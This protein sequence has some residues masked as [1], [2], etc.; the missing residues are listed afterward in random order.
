[1]IAG[2]DASEPF[3]P[4]EQPVQRVQFA[5]VLELERSPFAVPNETSEPFPKASGL[6][7]DIVELS[8]HRLRLQSFERLGRHK[9]RLFQPIQETI[10][11]VDPVDRRVHWGGYRIQKIQTER[12]G[13]EYGGRT[14][15]SH[16]SD[17]SV[18]RFGHPIVT[19]NL[20]G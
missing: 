14:A 11:I 3:V 2:H 19:N 20:S 4:F 13:N 7:R 1:M 16:L 17:L 8:R 12:V 15:V 5:Q 9:S 10:A 18:Q 6:S